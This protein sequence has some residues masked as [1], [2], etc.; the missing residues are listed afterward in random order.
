MKT[1]VFA[2]GSSLLAQGWTYYDQSKFKIILG[3][4]KRKIDNKNFNQIRFN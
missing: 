1:L 3:V 4:H 2:G